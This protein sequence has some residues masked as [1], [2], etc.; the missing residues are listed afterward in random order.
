MSERT[1]GALVYLTILSTI[2]AGIAHLPWW[3]A[4]AGVCL[5]IALSLQGRQSAIS[6]GEPGVLIG[7]EAAHLLAATLNG[8]TI[9]AAAFG[10]G[11]LTAWAWG[12]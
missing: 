5:L 10:F 4:A 11:R 9:I 1:H 6:R 2:I 3:L 8:S 12:V 7:S